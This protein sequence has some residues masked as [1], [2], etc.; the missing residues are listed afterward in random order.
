MLIL[1]VMLMFMG[2]LMMKIINGFDSDDTVISNDG[3]DIREI[4]TL[5]IRT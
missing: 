2:V 1:V 4:D 3:H 5:M